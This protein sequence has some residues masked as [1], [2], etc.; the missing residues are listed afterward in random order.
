MVKVISHNFLIR[1]SLRA[2]AILF[3]LVNMFF[4]FSCTKNTNAG[5]DGAI[6]TPSP[7]MTPE[8][9]P[10]SYQNDIDEYEP[11]DSLSQDSDGPVH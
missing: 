10:E 11:T 6:P 2:S 7:V 1:K 8:E 5:E 3:L 9:T 4:T